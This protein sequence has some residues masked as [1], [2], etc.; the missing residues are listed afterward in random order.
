L[1][2][3]ENCHSSGVAWVML[4]GCPQSCDRAWVFF[5]FPL[6]ARADRRPKPARTAVAT[7]WRLRCSIRCGEVICFLN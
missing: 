1:L 2:L 3:P 7:R 5:Y 4:P 6:L